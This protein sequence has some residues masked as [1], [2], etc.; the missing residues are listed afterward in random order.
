MLLI[1]LLMPQ[2]NSREGGHKGPQSRS[3]CDFTPSAERSLEEGRSFVPFNCPYLP[4]GAEKLNGC[5]PSGGP[6]IHCEEEEEECTVGCAQL[7]TP[8]GAQEK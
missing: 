6:S 4:F 5:P 8:V 1:S 7:S 2:K 3:C